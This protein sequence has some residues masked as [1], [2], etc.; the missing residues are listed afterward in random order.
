MAT[1]TFHPEPLRNPAPPLPQG[2]SLAPAQVLANATGGQTYAAA[3]LL[4]GARGGAWE[5]A[6]PGTRTSRHCIPHLPPLGT[7]A[8]GATGIHGKDENKQN[9]RRGLWK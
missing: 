4:G 9:S 6:G 1:V 7:I 5:G 2:G 8:A 3:H